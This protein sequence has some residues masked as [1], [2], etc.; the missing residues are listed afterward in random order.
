MRKQLLILSFAAI[1]TV[2]MAGEKEN[3]YILTLDG[4]SHEVKS[5]R[6]AQSGLA[7]G[8]RTHKPLRFSINPEESSP[9]CVNLADRLV[10]GSKLTDILI[11]MKDQSLK[12]VLGTFTLIG[13]GLRSISLPACDGASKD[14]AYIE[15]Q[16]DFQERKY[17]DFPKET[18]GPPRNNARSWTPGNFEI[19]IDG[20]A[21]FHYD[22]I[23]MITIS[24]TDDDGDG[25][26]DF[27]ITNPVVELAME[28]AAA[29]MKWPR[30]AASGLP[31]GKRMHIRYPFNNG[32][33]CAS[34]SMEVVPVSIDWANVFES[35]FPFSGRKVRVEF[36]A[37][38]KVGY[39][40]ALN[41][42][43]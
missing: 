38:K 4:L 19:D 21:S 2:S 11:D 9:L 29:L 3:R 24:K 32:Q 20:F 16:F 35:V 33:T 27:D 15:A 37:D 5:P 41:K 43:V 8:R 14:P 30:D 22:K 34:L 12:K 39:D 10:G 42:K 13:C 18:S 7:T 23:E 40:L 28:D 17:P 6:D 26:P 25:D 1:A 36:S 31:T